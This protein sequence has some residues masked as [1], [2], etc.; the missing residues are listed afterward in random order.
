MMYILSYYFQYI[1]A[2]IYTQY[3]VSPYV[4]NILQNVP[5]LDPSH[6]AFT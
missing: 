5:A 6:S 2:V 4:T 3:I 1:K